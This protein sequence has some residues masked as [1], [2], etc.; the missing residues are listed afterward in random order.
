MRTELAECPNC[1]VTL[2]ETLATRA[3]QK[4]RLAEWA[5]RAEEV[6]PEHAAEAESAFHPDV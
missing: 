6:D 3:E 1:R 2:K 4:A 5:A